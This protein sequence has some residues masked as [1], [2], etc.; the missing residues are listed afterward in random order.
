MIGPRRWLCLIA[1]AGALA[2]AGCA[3]RSTAP[4]AAEPAAG[5]DAAEP[6]PAD[7][8]PPEHER[9]L[10]GRAARAEAQGRWADAALTWEV[11]SVL[12]PQ[13]E[14]VR[15]RLGAARQRIDKLA[16]ERLAAAADAQRRGE[17]D[18][19]VQAYLEVLALD[20][21]RRAAADA[22]RQIERERTRRSAVGRFAAPPALRRAAE[23]EPPAS[24]QAG[25]AARAANSQ[26]EHAT[27]LARQGD[28]DGAI[29]LLRDSPALRHDAAHRSL[30]ADLYVQKAESL[31][32]RQPDQA[33]QAVNAALAL[34]R[35]H[36]GA[37]A[38]QS[39]LAVRG[40]KARGPAAGASAAAR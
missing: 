33:R 8:P 12:R 30:L 1:A 39:Q 17:L 16:G 14:R 31:R 24:T 38:L 35:R 26:R 2:L 23:T 34:D 13:D 37:L 40:G 20:P 3:S 19:A 9:L 27:M 29:Q 6:L 15:E 28:L 21:E 18:L 7:P 36:P 10:A 22:L 4:A 11:L 32:Q 25:E 5:A